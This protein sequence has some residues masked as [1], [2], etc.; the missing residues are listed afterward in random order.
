MA[1]TS[2][3]EL[4][5]VSTSGLAGDD[6]DIVVPSA[7]ALAQSGGRFLVSA[8]SLPEAPRFRLA[9]GLVSR[10]L[11]SLPAAIL[12]PEVLDELPLSLSSLVLLFPV[13]EELPEVLWLDEDDDVEDDE[14]ED[15]DLLR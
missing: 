7:V 15:R 14:S 3:P 10:D 13:C 12:S 1:A 2:R 9:A 5:L 8:T 4:V 6:G 11:A